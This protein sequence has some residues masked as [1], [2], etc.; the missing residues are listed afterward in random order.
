MF[1]FRLDDLGLRE[2]HFFFGLR[3]SDTLLLTAEKKFWR[4]V[5]SGEA[6]RL[7]GVEPGGAASSIHGTAKPASLVPGSSRTRC[8]PPGSQ[9]RDRARLFSVG[10]RN[11]MSIVAPMSLTVSGSKV[12]FEQSFAIMDWLS[13]V[14]TDE[15]RTVILSLVA[16]R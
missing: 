15:D 6:P 11:G 2:A 12:C 1:A 8:G 7:F 3:R 9:R 13:E 10:R 14:R 5:A 4:C 16:R